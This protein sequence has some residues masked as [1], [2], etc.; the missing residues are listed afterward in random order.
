MFL[1]SVCPDPET[2]IAGRVSARMT[3]QAHSTTFLVGSLLGVM[4]VAAHVDFVHAYACLSDADCQYAGCK[5]IS[6]SWYESQLGKNSS[7]TSCNNGVWDAVCLYGRCMYL[8]LFSEW[9]QVDCPEPL[10]LSPVINCSRRSSS[11]LQF[12]CMNPQKLS[13]IRQA[14]P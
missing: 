2:H 6:C 8:D 4:I 11:I 13:Q 5:D 12:P 14:M 9:H 1:V 3:R 10:L 7:S